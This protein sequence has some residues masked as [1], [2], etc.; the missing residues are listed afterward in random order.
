VHDDDTN[1]L[2]RIFNSEP[3]RVP[4][5]VTHGIY[6]GMIII[7]MMMMMMMMMMMVFAITYCQPGARHVMHIQTYIVLK[8][9][10]IIQ[11]NWHHSGVL[12]VRIEDEIIESVCDFITI[13]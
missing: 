6:L 8:T 13:S 4:L 11:S 7:T 9:Q 10:P 2:D 5:L 12:V 3:L 1:I